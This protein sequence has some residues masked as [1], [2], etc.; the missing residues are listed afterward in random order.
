[1]KELKKLKTKIILVSFVP[2]AY[3]AFMI[4]DKTPWIGNLIWGSIDGAY[5]SRQ[6]GIGWGVF[7][8]LFAWRLVY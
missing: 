7:W 8:I 4:L 3:G 5:V 2:M 6:I 1:M